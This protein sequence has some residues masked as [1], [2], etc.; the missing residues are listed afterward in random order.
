MSTCDF[1]KR[2]QQ[3]I[4]LLITLIVT[5]ATF[6]IIASIN[7][8]GIVIVEIPYT[9]G[10]YDEYIIPAMNTTGGNFKAINFTI[11][12]SQFNIEF[13]AFFFDTEVSRWNTSELYTNLM[14]N[15]RDQSPN[16][17][18]STAHTPK[19]PDGSRTFNEYG[20]IADSFKVP[21]GNGL[22]F[23][24]LGLSVK[25]LPQRISSSIV[26]GLGILPVIED[27]IVDFDKYRI[28]LNTLDF[29]PDA[30]G[31]YYNLMNNRT[32][33]ISSFPYFLNIEVEK[34]P[35]SILDLY[36]YYNTV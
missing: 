15:W 11:D 12:G 28:T 6:S 36:Q 18:I 5:I 32:E 4:G 33:S 10:A 26:F 24:L 34:E 21:R 13:L 19:F 23:I 27:R 25:N 7:T 30:Y 2:K 17:N 14:L 31:E 9:F 8:D 22:A 1:K 3:N 29:N 16:Y 35:I 20:G